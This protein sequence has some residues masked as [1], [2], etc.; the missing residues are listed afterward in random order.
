[1]IIRSALARLLQPKTLAVIG[2]RFAEAVIEQCDRIGFEGEIYPINPKRSEMAGRRCFARIADLPQ[3]PDACFIAVEREAT[4]QA[5]A[6]LSARGAGGAV[7]YASGFAEVGEEGKVWQDRLLEAAKGMPLVGPNC[8]GLLNYLDG[9]AL[10]PDEHGGKAAEKGAGIVLQSGNIGLNLTMQERGLPLAYLISIGNGA[11]LQ[12]HDYIEAFLADERVTCIG[13]HI[14]GLKDV[15]AFTKAALKALKRK[16]PIVVL[17]TGTSVEGQKITFGHTSSLSGSDD[18]Y[19]AML[20]RYGVARVHTLTEFLET[21]K[22]LSTVGSLPNKKI[23]SISCSGGEAAHVADLAGEVGL[24]FPPLM[25][26]QEQALSDALG[27]KVALSNPLDYHTYIWNDGVAQE[28]CFSAMLTGEQS[29]TLNLLDYPKPDLCDVSAWDK[30]AQAFINALKATGNKGVVVGTLPENL[31]ATTRAWLMSEGIAPMQ[32]LED[33]LLSIHHAARLYERQQGA[34]E[35]EPLEVTPVLEGETKTL[36]EWES[37]KLLHTFGF[38]V[39]EARVLSLND[40]DA[41]RKSCDELG[42][43]LALKIL[44]ADIIHKTDVGGVRLNLKTFDAVAEAIQSM[45]SLGDTFLAEQMLAKPITELILG[46]TRGEQFGLSITLGAGGV[47]VELLQDIQ[48]LLVPVTATEVEDAIKELKIYPLLK[49]FRGGKGA[50]LEPII[51]AV[52]NLESFIEVHADTLLELDI[53]PLFVFENEVVVAD[54]LIRTV[55]S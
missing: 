20:A 1:M 14:E 31:P 44:S 30:T 29:V 3:A 13:L 21:L 6:K 17:K 27:D 49:G 19:S 10:W 52:M 22:L 5:V 26:L 32:G 41:A 35:L 43:P 55:E 48:T 18:L 24:E 42:Y 4:V 53:N 36:N 8:Y 50:R 28:R 25:P 2:G 38:T 37:K 7:C 34:E 45:Q 9:L 15:P 40:L 33:C 16:V 11:D 47:L 51:Q 46:V 12:M 23:A 54:A 39:P